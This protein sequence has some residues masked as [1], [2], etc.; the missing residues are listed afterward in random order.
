MSLSSAPPADEILSLNTGFNLGSDSLP[1]ALKFA[2]SR[3]LNASVLVSSE[4]M[5]EPIEVWGVFKISRDSFSFTPTVGYDMINKPAYDRNKSDEDCWLNLRPAV[6]LLPHGHDTILGGT[7]TWTKYVANIKSI[8]KL[9]KDT[10]A[11]RQSV[12]LENWGIKLSHKFLVDKPAPVATTDSDTE[13]EGEA[14]RAS[15]ADT[16]HP[17]FTLEN[18]PVPESWDSARLSLLDR[19]YSIRPLEA[20]IHKKEEPIRPSRYERKLKGAI[21]HVSFIIL[22]YK[23]AQDNR[24]RFSA[25]A[26]RITV[27]I[28]PT[29]TASRGKGKRKETETEAEDTHKKPKLTPTNE[30]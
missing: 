1:D 20:Y 5:D 30:L 12:L 14:D 10:K 2:Y 25:V 16:I 22:A 28:T 15:P 29:A 7:S 24:I 9:Y 27:L 17:Q 6:N 21:A 11:S 26:R 3:D 13:E 23:F 8:E 4:A 19:G 18:W